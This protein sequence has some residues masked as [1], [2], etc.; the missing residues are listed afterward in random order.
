MG[1]HDDEAV[2]GDFGE[3]V[4]DLDARLG[5]ERAGGLVGKEDFRVVDEGAGDGDA[6][7]LAAGKLA[8]LLVDVVG[9]PHLPQGFDG[10]RAALGARHARKRERELDVGKDGLVGDEV[11][12]LEHEPD[13]VVAERVPIAVLVFLG[14]HAV[15][16]EVARVVVVEP[17][18]DVEHGG[19]ARPRRAE[20]GHELV[21]AEG[22]GHV[23]ERDLGEAAGCVCL[24]DIAQLEHFG[25]FRNKV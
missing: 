17:A 2:V 14:G 24:A 9:K 12:A 18:D 15:D 5:I 7:H 20:D 10:A 13:A 8:R 11:V 1:D 21:V 22:N 16:D 4:H 25:A 23:V 19:L 6:L 3:Q